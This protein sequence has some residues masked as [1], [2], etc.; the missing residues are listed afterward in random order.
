MTHCSTCTCFP[1]QDGYIPWTQPWPED[2]AP[3]GYCGGCGDKLLERPDAPGWH[4]FC[5]VAAMR[6]IADVDQT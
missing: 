4:H 5:R 2:Y 1:D 3:W 6:R